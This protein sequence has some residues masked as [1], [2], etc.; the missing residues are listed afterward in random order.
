MNGLITHEESQAVTKAFRE[1]GHNFY[2]NDLKQCSGGHPEWHVKGDCF[3]VLRE[4]LGLGRLQFVGMHPVCRYL[5][6]SGVR[7]L[8][9]KKPREG[10][11]WS[12]TYQIYINPKRYELMRSAALDFV[13]CLEWVDR[14]GIGYV[15]NPIMHK[16]ARQIIGVEP[17]QIIQPWMHGHTESKATC[18]WLL[19]IDR[20]EETN[21]VYEQMERLPKKETDKTHYASPGPEREKIR[22]KTYPGIAKALAEQ[23]SKKFI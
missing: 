13:K 9:S 17:T 22:S 7:W 6:N 23:F 16:Y 19:G 8:A 10:Y 15:E 3:Y 4:F 5:A 1:L 14:V 18:L 20:L 21:N 11:V 12:E 2:S